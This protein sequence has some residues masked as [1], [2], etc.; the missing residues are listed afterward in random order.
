MFARKVRDGPEMLNETQYLF[1]AYPKLRDKQAT[2]S[3]EWY[4]SW[5]SADYIGDNMKLSFGL[6]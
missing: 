2:N 1:S 6:F 5:E 3:C 4:S